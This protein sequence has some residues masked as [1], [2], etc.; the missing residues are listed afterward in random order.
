[1]TAT[2][3]TC[4]LQISRCR[5]VRRAGRFA[6]SSRDVQTAIR[7]KTSSTVRGSAA[8]ATAA[9]AELTSPWSLTTSSWRYRCLLPWR[10]RTLNLPQHATMAYNRITGCQRYVFRLTFSA[11]GN[12]TVLRVWLAVWLIV[13]TVSLGKRSYSTPGPVSTGMGDRVWGSTPDA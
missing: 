6:T 1:M 7:C 13:V 3:S 8:S 5:L 2:R 12:E 10:H 9:S 4:T 11:H